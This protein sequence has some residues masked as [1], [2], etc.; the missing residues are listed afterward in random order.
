MTMWN[1]VALVENDGKPLK[2]LHQDRVGK[3][4]YANTPMRFF[5]SL[6]NGQALGFLFDLGFLDL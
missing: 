2:N 1:I 3:F 6:E 5:L 4:E